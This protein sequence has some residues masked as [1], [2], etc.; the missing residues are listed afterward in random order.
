[1]KN[2]KISVTDLKKHALGIVE[3]V[4]KQSTNITVTKRN[5]PIVTISPI[6]SNIQ[7]DTY[8][9]FMKGKSKICQDIVNCSFESEW[10][11]LNDEK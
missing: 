5:I 7:K 4:R 2:K 8:F 9:G 10:D 1:M 11:L 6:Q 3:Q